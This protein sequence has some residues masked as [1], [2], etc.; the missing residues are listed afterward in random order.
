MKK[1]LLV[2]LVAAALVLVACALGDSESLCDAEEGPCIGLRFDGD[3]CTF[4]G[5]TDTRTGEFTIILVNEGEGLANF[6]LVSVDEG[7][8]LEDL[9]EEVATNPRSPRPPA[10]ISPVGIWGETVPVGETVSVKRIVLPGDYGVLCNR[11]PQYAINGDGFT[12][13]S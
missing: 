11:V 8:T 4:E 1:L 2:L 7:M 6:E 13:E 9:E 3:N 12:I 10:W 5:P